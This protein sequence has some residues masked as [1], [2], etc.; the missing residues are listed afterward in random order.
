MEGQAIRGPAALLL[1]LS[2]TGIALTG[3]IADAQEPSGNRKQN[4]EIRMMERALDAML[5]DSPNYLVRGYDNSRGIYIPGTGAIFTFDASLVASGWN[6][7]ADHRKWYDWSDEDDD[8]DESRRGTRSR[9]LSRQEKQY[10]RGVEELQ[11]LLLDHG[12]LLT[13][14]KPGETVQLIAFFDDVDYLWDKD[15]DHLVVKARVEDLRSYADKKM[16]EDQAKA[17]ITTSEY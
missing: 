5:I 2:V 16:N 6:Y 8:D 15:I 9:R 7:N 14:L 12:D 13:T 11:E 3:T 10:T 17:K 1:F 4:R